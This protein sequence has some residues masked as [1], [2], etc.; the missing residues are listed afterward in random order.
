MKYNSSYPIVMASLEEKINTACII[1]NLII[2]MLSSYNCIMQIKREYRVNYYR[3][4]IF[5]E[6]TAFSHTNNNHSY[7]VV[8]AP[9]AV[10]TEA[11]ATRST[12]QGE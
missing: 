8:T 6:M 5:D 3:G 7:A 9:A 11:A 2:R 10:V 12:Y 4:L 1:I